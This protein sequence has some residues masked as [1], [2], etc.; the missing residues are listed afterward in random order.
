MRRVAELMHGAEA[1]PLVTTTTMMGEALLTMS[2]RGFGITAVAAED[3]TLAGIVTDGD[4]R[5]NLDNLMSHTAGDIATRDPVT[6]PP[7]M[8]AAQALALMNDRKISV[9]LVVDEQRRP[10]G[11]LHIHDCLRAGVA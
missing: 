11:I 3:G 9:L 4:L 5:R 6:V 7:D 2:V 1:L 8:L 10:V